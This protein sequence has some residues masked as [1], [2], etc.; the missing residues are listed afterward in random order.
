MQERLKAEPRNHFLRGSALF[1]NNLRGVTEFHNKNIWESA[2][3]R[4]PECRNRKKEKN[5]SPVK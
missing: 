3:I 1:F 2:N 5:L 4:F